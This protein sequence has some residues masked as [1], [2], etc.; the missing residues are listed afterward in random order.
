M[1]RTVFTLLCV[2]T[3]GLLPVIGNAHEGHDDISSL[4]GSGDAPSGIPLTLSTETITNLDIRTRKAE[5]KP[6]PDVISMPAI[7]TLMPDKQAQITTRFDGQVRDIKVKLGQE[8][9]KGQELITVEPVPMASNIIT[10]KSPINGQVITQNV[11]LGQSVTFETAM[12]EIADASQ[13]L[14]KGAIYETPEL[15][16]IQI[17]QKVTAQMGIYPG[18]RFE[19]IVEKIDAGPSAD[20]RA[21]HIYALLDNAD[22]ALK[23]NLRGT[24]SVELEGSNTPTISV[25]VSSV[26]ENNGVS[27]LFVRDGEKFERRIIQTGR[28]SGDEMEIISGLFPDEEVVTQGNYQLQYLKP[29]APKAET[30][31]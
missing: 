6:L 2:L 18:R 27:F 31:H 3:L 8:V 12:I 11:V 29:D 14:L 15:A 10:L 13:I 5:I 9:R 17:G 26:I 28:R 24:M 22:R 25:P 21:L 1:T 4:T 7:V 16:K 23:P 19:G 20:S 30:E